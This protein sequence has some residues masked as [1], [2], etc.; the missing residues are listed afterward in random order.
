MSTFIT[1]SNVSIEANKFMLHRLVPG[2]AKF[3]TNYVVRSP[4]GIQYMRNGDYVI[5]MSSGSFFGMPKEVFDLLM[6]EKNG[7]V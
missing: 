7:N 2:I 3:C 4:I 5:Q 6:E 1:K